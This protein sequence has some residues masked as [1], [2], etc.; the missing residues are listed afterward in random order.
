MM[1]WL[2]AIHRRLLPPDAEIGWQPYLWLV[3]AG[4]FF[5]KYLVYDAGPIERVAIAVTIPA[6]L[7]VYFIAYWRRGWRL[8][9]ALAAFG[10]LGTLWAPHNV[11]ANVFFIYGCAFVGWIGPVRRAAF[12][13]A[14]M[15]AW[16]MAVAYAW[17]PHIGYW[18]PVLVFGTLTGLIGIFDAMRVRAAGELRLSQ[19]E[20]R[21]MAQVAER[22]RISR[23]L[24]DVLGHTLSV[25]TLK[26]ALAG[27]LLRR[28][29]DRAAAEIGE[30]ERVS[31]AALGEVREAITGIRAHGLR[32]E[33]EYARVALK[34]AGVQVSV[35]GE[36]SQLPPANEAVLAMVLRE[37]VTNVVRHAEASRCR[38]ALRNEGGGTFVEVHDDGRGGIPVAGGGIQGMRARLAT[39]GG[40][41]DVGDDFGI[42]LRAWLPL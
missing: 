28:E 13:I 10:I 12:A 2:D 32:G 31:R 11:G 14:A 15:V 27:R 4:F 9:P 30:I 29:P 19:E 23:D 35:D 24:H 17:Q 42:R 25:I 16:A 38:I 39:A 1:R 22:E 18:L 37:A 21:Q 41:L 40:R 26:A 5:M 8:L 3:F 20:V 33:L 7:A 34:A 36:L 6:F